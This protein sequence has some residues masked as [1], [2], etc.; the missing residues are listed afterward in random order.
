MWHKIGLKNNIFFTTPLEINKIDRELLIG[1]NNEL[2]DL[3]REINSVDNGIRI[4]TGKYGIGKTSLLNITQLEVF[5]NN[6][7]YKRLLPAYRKIRL[8]NET[9]YKDFILETILSLC[10][11]IREYFIQSN[12]AIPDSIKFQVDYW[13]GIK[14]NIHSTGREVEFDLQLI[15]M[16]S[17]SSI[18]DMIW[19]QTDPFYSLRNLLDEFIQNTDV[20]GVFF[21]I[22]NLELIENN[23]LIDILNNSRD[24][25]F[26]LKNTYWFLCS[27]DE[28]LP[29]EI[30]VKSPRFSSIITGHALNLQKLNSTDVIKA[31]ESR[32]EMSK[33]NSQ[34]VIPLP[35]TEDVIRNV[36]SFTNFDLRESFKIFQYLASDF[37]SYDETSKAFLEGKLQ[38][39]FFTV[40]DALI[41][42]CL[43]YTE[44]IPL[45]RKECELLDYIFLN[46][47]CTLQTIKRQNI[48]S[49]ST[50]N[51]RL[52]KMISMGLIKF[53]TN[54]TISLTFR[55]K[56]VALS[57]RLS[58]KANN[59]ASNEILLIN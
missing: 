55:L 28:N 37:Y 41:E 11:N 57:L 7:S 12:Q 51:G 34:T 50:I 59:M 13:L 17:N 40:K 15:K 45:T 24:T 18:T 30:Y 39:D 26:T 20:T 10:E 14:R 48:F 16:K 42:Y 1:R 2:A 21:H 23:I 19:N 56:T 3:T 6:T 9:K 46:S 5:Q 33:L 32:I 49:S 44:F 47:P 36:Y 22:D 29:N 8:D 35:F 43:K 52:K 25:L 27:S 58:K 54:T 4:I 31:I 38:L 53:D